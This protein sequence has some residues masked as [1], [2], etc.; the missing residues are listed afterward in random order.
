MHAGSHMRKPIAI[1]VLAIALTQ[2]GQVNTLTNG[3]KYA[4]AVAGAIEQ[5]MGTKPQVGFN[6]HNGRLL[7]VTVQFSEL[8]QRKPLNEL[9]GRV[10]AVV[11][12]EFQ[13]KPEN[14]ILGFR[15]DG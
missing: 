10:R 2:C 13:Q 12:K 11:E 5:E 8:Y 15:I 4:N 1:A 14:I 6:W 7:S 9:A 3:F